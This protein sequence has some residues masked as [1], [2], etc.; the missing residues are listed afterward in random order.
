RDPAGND[1]EGFTTWFVG[2]AQME[3]QI[4]WGLIEPVL[5]SFCE[6]LNSK[7]DDSVIHQP[8]GGITQLTVL[9]THGA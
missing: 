5:K 8:A 9:D 4:A 2:Q 7:S 3:F 6:Y 1:R